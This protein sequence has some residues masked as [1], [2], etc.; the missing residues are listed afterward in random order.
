[1]HHRFFLRPATRSTRSEAGSRAR[2][3]LLGGAVFL[4]MP[5][6]APAAGRA[7][8]TQLIDAT[9]DGTNPLAVGSAVATD[10]AGNAFVS[11][12]GTDNAFKIT[13]GGA[14]TQ[15]IDSTGDGTNGLDG[16]EELATDG[17]G[18]V[19]AAG[20]NSDNVFKITPGG[21]ITE[22]IDS[23]GD[24]TNRLD[25]A[26]DVATDGAGNVFV[27]GSLSQNVF[28]I[29]PGGTITQIIDSTGDGTN[30][31]G[32]PTGV[33]TDGAGNVFV[34]GF[35]TNNAFKITPGGVITQIIDSDGDGTN[36]LDGANSV[37]TDASGNVFVGGYSS[38]NVF[39]ITPGGTIT[40]IIDST[41]DGTNPLSTVDGTVATDAAGN[42]FVAGRGSSNAFEITPGG[43]ITEIID[44]TG[45]GT[46]PLNTTLDVA[47]DA[48]GNVFVA[49]GFGNNAF[50][51]AL[52]PPVVSQ[53]IRGHSLLVR[54][55]SLGTD[56]IKRRVQ[57]RAK[58]KG[59]DATIVG[60]PTVAGATLEIVANGA[61]PTSQTFVLPAAFWRKSSGIPGIRFQ[62]GDPRGENGPV[63]GAQ[64]RQSS[65]GLFSIR[66]DVAGRSGILPLD[67]VPPNDGTDGFVVLEITG[68]DRYCVQYG[69]DG[70][71]RNRGAGW[72]RVTSPTA[73]GC[74]P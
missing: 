73:E 30:G 11:G 33:A 29:T 35:S 55:D 64:I 62:Y 26:F 72:F 14:I 66:V 34:C 7:Q 50:K 36:G 58:E 23:T 70:R 69:A 4:A 46:D 74:P 18:N 5:L 39:K 57:A 16:L 38:S 15:I 48:L 41:G 54:D 32:L 61:N 10:G 8:I 43:T 6:L 44:A 53:T 52:A 21:A 17:A 63:T 20:G 45:D 65:G 40:Q 19:F 59:S 27:S 31:L 60:D 3:V 1:M 49:G 22:I 42:V 67:V 9:G 25:R 37:G 56:P 47:T 12:F 24:G 13:P 2:Q 51:I 28:R 71:V 68:G